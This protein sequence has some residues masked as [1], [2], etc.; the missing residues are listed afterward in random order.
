M[1]P[2]QVGGGTDTDNTDKSKGQL[3]NP[4]LGFNMAAEV[5]T[6]AAEVAGSG[7]QAGIEAEKAEEGISGHISAVEGMAQLVG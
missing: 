1:T 7:G 5:E 3:R 4:K 2:E 6:G